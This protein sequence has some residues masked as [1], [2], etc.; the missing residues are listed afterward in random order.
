M[1]H[2]WLYSGPLTFHNCLL[3]SYIN[4]PTHFLHFGPEEEGSEVRNMIIFTTLT[5]CCTEETLC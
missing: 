1:N 3:N 5:W 4:P 2:D